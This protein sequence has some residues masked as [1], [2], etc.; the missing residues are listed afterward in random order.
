[1]SRCL[2]V[3]LLLACWVTTAAYAGEEPP[4]FGRLVFAQSWHDFGAVT[5]GDELKHTFTFEVMDG[6]VVIGRIITGCG[7]TVANM[8]KNDYEAGELGEIEI[9]VDTSDSNGLL[10]KEILIEIIDGAE[11]TMDL[12]LTATVSKEKN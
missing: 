6:P 10:Y 2:S 9:T 8:R 12:G 11:S 1:M 7:C 5:A 3:L 4:P